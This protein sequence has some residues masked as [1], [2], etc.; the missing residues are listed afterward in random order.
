[1]KQLEFVRRGKL[2]WK[3]VAEPKIQGPL[4]AIVKPT[5]MGRCD[6]DYYILLGIT[7]FQPPFVP[8]HEFAGEIVEVGEGVKNLHKGQKVIV[9]FHISCGHCGKCEK[10]IYSFCETVTYP[11]SFGLGSHAGNFGGGLSDLVRVPFAES[12]LY[13]V[14]EG[15]DLL[16][17]FAAAD[18][19]SDGWRAVGPYLE[20]NPQQDVLILSNSC[21]GLY[22]A[23]IAKAM[24][25]EKVDYIDTNRQRLEIAESL[26][27]TAIES[28]YKE[29]FGKYMLT[30]DASA[31]EKGIRSA[32]R[33]TEPGGTCTSTGIYFSNEIKFPLWD[34][35]NNDITFKT[36][37][38]HSGKYIPKVMDL[39]QTKKIEPQKVITKKVPWEDA[40]EGYK[41]KTTK[42]VVI[43]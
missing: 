13:P 24:G 40:K 21:L 33:S 20:E 28:E 17:V 16:D 23:M 8:G 27:V 41:E 32:L 38:A 6:L 19:L 25:A 14:P 5:V 11:S 29:S 15:V 10:E 3:E 9:P 4:E 35:Y 18:N 1:M 36:G 7:P 31:S 26:G 12:M 30:V 43:R 34:M 37:V 2:E 42:L 22:A 39:L